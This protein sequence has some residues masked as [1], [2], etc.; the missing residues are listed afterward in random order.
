[1]SYNLTSE[2]KGRIS[3]P[4]GTSLDRYIVEIQPALMENWW[5]ETALH[6]W[7][8][9]KDEAPELDSQRGGKLVDQVTDNLRRRVADVVPGLFPYVEFRKRSES[10]G[11]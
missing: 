6:I 7:V 4:L 5:G 11:G 2:A 10:A 3:E 8:V 1:M 9:L